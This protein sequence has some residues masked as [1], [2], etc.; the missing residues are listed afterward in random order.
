MTGAFA[1]DLERVDRDLRADP[2][3]GWAVMAGTLAIA[4]PL[5]IYRTARSRTGE[6]EVTFREL[7]LG[8]DMP[9]S[10]VVGSRTLEAEEK[11]ASGEAGEGLEGTAVKRIVVPNAGHLMMFDNPDGFAEA[12][13]QALPPPR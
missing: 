3:S 8:L 11:P 4:S 7:L 13:A 1:A 9:R 5:A 6:R 10:F 12:I 2:H